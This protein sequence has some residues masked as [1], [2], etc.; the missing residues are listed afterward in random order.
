M[1]YRPIEPRW[2]LSLAMTVVTIVMTGCNQRLRTEYGASKG[3]RGDQSING[4]G[5]LRRAY[6]HEGWTTR[7]ITRLNSRLKNVDAIVWTPTVRDSLYANATAWFDKWLAEEKRTLIYVVPD[8]GCELAYFEKASGLAP[9]KQ[10]MEY[11]RRIATLISAQLIERLQ[12]GVIMSNGWFQIERLADRTK[13]ESSQLP[14]GDAT[15]RYKVVVA[16]TVANPAIANPTTV[17]PSAATPQPPTTQPSFPPASTTQPPA[18]QPTSPPAPTN[19]PLGPAGMT[20]GNST[21]TLEHRSIIQ[22][23]DGSPVVVT[24]TAKEWNDSKIIV[25]GC[26]SLL[27]NYTLAS[28]QG[29][30]LAA[31]L[32]ADTSDQP[33][34]VGF[35][36]SNFSGVSVT[37]ADPE[38][39]AMTGLELLTIWPLSLIMFHLIVLGFFSCMVLLPIFGR[40]RELVESP[41]S[42]FSDHIDAVAAL[43]QKSGGEQYARRRVSDYMK[44]IRGE[45]SGPWLL[46]EPTPKPIIAASAETNLPPPP[47]EPS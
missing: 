8:G 12:D 36:S 35:I 24:I 19:L 46:P 9:P 17:N 32:I 42:N 28:P 26:G 43:M 13:I 33:G 14:D 10:K 34:L 37:E 6:L 45:S 7:D 44:R 18:T 20:Y 23:A 25:V 3:S 47:K 22:A 1:S 27:C 4:F 29:Q 11:R 39:N 30:A 41:D 16:N 38:I 2:T 40:P 5:V 15:V 31:Q 21:L